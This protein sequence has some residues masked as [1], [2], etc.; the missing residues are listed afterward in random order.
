MY[1]YDIGLHEE[2][3][4]DLLLSLLQSLRYTERIQRIHRRL[5]L[6]ACLIVL[7][8]DRFKSSHHKYCL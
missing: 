6:G 7:T 8:L 1:L 5:L 2:L 3:P 4:G